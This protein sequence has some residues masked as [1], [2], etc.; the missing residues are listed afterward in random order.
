MGDGGAPARARYP[1]L[2]VFGD[3]EEGGENYYCLVMIVPDDAV[4]A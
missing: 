3:G 1:V 2:F 4:R